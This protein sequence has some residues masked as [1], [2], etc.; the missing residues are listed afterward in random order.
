[1][2]T[3]A[4]VARDAAGKTHRGRAEADNERNLQKRLRESGYFVTEIK[5]ER[6]AAQAGRKKAGFL[7]GFQKVKLNHLSLFCRQFAT[8]INAGVSLVRCLAVLEQQTP[9]ARMRQIIRELQTDVEAGE[10]LSRSM[11]KHP[12]VFDNLFIGLVRAGEVGGV[13]DE[14]LERLSGFL[15]KIVEMRRKIKAAMT[16]PIIVFIVAIL[17]VNGLVIFI[18][19][20]FMEIFKEF[21]VEM[22]APTQFLMDLSA[23]MRSRNGVIAMIVGPI[24]AY[25]LFRAFI[26][27]KFGR[28]VWDWVKLKVPVFGKLNHNLSVSRFARTLSTLLGSGVPILQ[29]METTAGAV[30][31]EIVAQAI[32]DSRASIREGERIGDPLEKSKL[33]P[34]MVVQMIAIGEET[35]TLDSMLGKVADYYESEVDAQ[36]QSLAAAIEPLMI[37]FLGFIVG[38]I[39]ISM[40]LPLLSIISNLSQ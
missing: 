12:R 35:G 19:P 10:M 15:E 16:Y 33:F 39:V 38:F 18:L 29:A 37:V 17:I 9:S 14:T 22:P 27:T 1:M 13:L 4:Y 23:F 32:M 11:A 24:V 40:F 28:R 6:D 8:M 5:R 21:K 26:R 36:L 31:N 20:K 34:P 3:F 25:L 30:N 2:P 7:T